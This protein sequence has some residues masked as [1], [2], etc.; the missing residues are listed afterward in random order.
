MADNFN[1]KRK[2]EGME[3]SGLYED[4]QMQEDSS[5]PYDNRMYR[6]PYRQQDMEIDDEKFSEDDD[7]KDS[8]I[9]EGS[10]KANESEESGEDLIENMDNDYKAIPELDR[11]EKEGIDDNEN[12]D[13]RLTAEQRLQVDRLLNERD[14]KI[15]A[16]GQRRPVTMLDDDSEDDDLARQLR[17]ERLKI[18]QEQ[19]ADGDEED[20]AKYLDIEE[21]KG[22]ITEW[23]QQPR[24]IKFI[25]NQFSAFLRNF[26]DEKGIDVYEQRITE[27]CSNNKQSL[28]VTYSH[29]SL[30]IPT[31][32]IWVAEWPS[33]IFPIFN[34][35]AFELVT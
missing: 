1:R 21:A 2:F 25:R 6:Q 4:S 18:T 20:D 28:E 27:M 23:L 31:L 3:G 34:E 13:R 10:D 14:R 16:K 30:K 12:S 8:E 22:N 33:L 19:E 9:I 26:K 29:L 24:T 11:Y 17:R 32:T 15:A 7:A 35:V 5:Q